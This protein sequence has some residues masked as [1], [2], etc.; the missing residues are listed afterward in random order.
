MEQPDHIL[1]K[2]TQRF[3]QAWV[4]T[5][6]F[7]VNAV[8]LYSVYIQVIKKEILNTELGHHSDATGRSVHRCHLAL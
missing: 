3:R 4:L 2:E 5:L 8:A 1:F 7:A 6:L